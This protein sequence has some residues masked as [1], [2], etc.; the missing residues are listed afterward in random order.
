MKSCE[1]NST[2]KCRLQR[3]WRCSFTFNCKLSIAIER[4]P[5]NVSCPRCRQSKPIYICHRCYRLTVSMYLCLAHSV[6]EIET[7][8]PRNVISNVMFSK[9]IHFLG[10]KRNNTRLKLLCHPAD[11]PPFS[12][13]ASHFSV[14]CNGHC[15]MLKRYLY[16]RQHFTRHY[17]INH[18]SIN[19]DY[20]T[21]P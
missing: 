20:I 19:F 11:Y 4:S 17:N 9:Y 7:T 5:R 18:C 1:C 13:F 15:N 3:C 21:R 6:P 2:L 10:N 12:L 8:I 16:W 14:H